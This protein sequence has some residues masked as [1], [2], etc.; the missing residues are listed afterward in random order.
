M[1][2]HVRQISYRAVTVTL[3]VLLSHVLATTT[4][5][6][7]NSIKLHARKCEIKPMA[8][9]RGNRC[10]MPVYEIRSTIDHYQTPTAYSC[11]QNGK[12]YYI[13]FSS[14]NM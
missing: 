9:A 8:A 7:H 6:T 13:M 14:R 5:Y 2:L 10:I 4:T 3:S 12:I 11:E 1:L